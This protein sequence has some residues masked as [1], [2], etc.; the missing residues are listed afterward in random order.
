MHTKFSNPSPGF[1]IYLASRTMV[2]SPITHSRKQNK[3]VFSKKSDQPNKKD[4]KILTLGIIN[5]TDQADHS[6]QS[7]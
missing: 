6:N 1:G 7:F 4:L 2:A 5:E 3:G